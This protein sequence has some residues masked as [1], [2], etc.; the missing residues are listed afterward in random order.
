MRTFFSF[1]GKICCLLVMTA[2]GIS[3][4]AQSYRWENEKYVEPLSSWTGNPLLTVQHDYWDSVRVYPG[5][6]YSRHKFKSLDNY[7]VL[8]INHQT[9][10]KVPDFN[11]RFSFEIRGYRSNG[12]SLY[13]PLIMT[14]EYKKD[15]LQD[16]KDQEIVKLPDS[17]HY[18]EIRLVEVRTNDANNTLVPP[19]SIPAN[20]FLEGRIYCQRY[21]IFTPPVQTNVNVSNQVTNDKLKVYWDFTPGSSWN[22]SQLPNDHQLT[23]GFYEL[24]WMYID[25]Y[26]ITNFDN[27]TSA[28][29]FTSSSFSL[30]YDFRNN[31]TRVQTHRNYYEIPLIYGKGVLIYRV[32]QIRPDATNY[33]DLV[34]GKWT[35]PDAGTLTQNSFGSSFPKCMANV[36][37][38][39]QQAHTQDKVNW[40][41]N[42]SFAEEGRQK[43]V[44]SYFDGTGKSRQVQ[45]RLSSDPGYVVVV[46]Q[47]YDAEGRAAITTLPIPVQSSNLDYKN[48]IAVNALT[49]LP[50]KATDFDNGCAKDT[51]AGLLPGSNGA[52][53]YSEDNPD[54]T[55]MQQF[56]PDA[57]G[58]PF[59]ETIYSPDATNKV[60]WQGGAG[61]DFQRTG[62]GTS[63]T[64]VTAHQKELNRY[65]GSEA[66]YFQYYP[67][68]FVQDPNGES[69][70]SIISP[71][72]KVVLS[73]LAGNA[74][75][76]LEPLNSVPAVELTTFDV[77]R[78]AQQSTGKAY[79]NFSYGFLPEGAGTNTYTY[80]GT[81]IPYATG[82]P[83]KY[84]RIPGYYNI[85]VTTECGETI[86]S[87]S[88]STGATFELTGSAARYRIA[89]GTTNFDPTTD[90]HVI[91]KRLVFPDTTIKAAARAFT[92][93][94]IGPSAC[95]ADSNKFIRAEIERQVFPCTDVPEQS[96]CDLM[97]RSLMDDLYPD[98]KYGIF[99]RNAEGKFGAGDTN[100]IFS[101]VD[102]DGFLF[103][104]PR[105]DKLYKFDISHTDCNVTSVVW[106][107]PPNSSV[108]CP[109]VFWGGG[110]CN[111][112]TFSV[113]LPKE[114]F[115]V[116]D[117]FF[118]KNLRTIPYNNPYRKYVTADTFGHPLPNN[119][120][121]MITGPVDSSDD[122]MKYRYQSSCLG[123]KK[124]YAG[125]L[126]PGRYYQDS[127]L[128]AEL[129]PDQLILVFNDAIA[130][131]LL[132]LHPEYCKLAAC[133]STGFMD[134]LARVQDWND[135]RFLGYETLDDIVAAD[136]LNMA[137]NPSA[138]FN[139]AQLS[140]IQLGYGPGIDIDSFA[141]MQTY[142]SNTFAV[143]ADS[144][145]NR[146]IELEQIADRL[147][148][149]T[150][151]KGL[152]ARNLV[153][154]YTSN[155]TM[156]MQQYRDNTANTCAPCDKLRM[157]IYGSPTIPKIFSG[158]QLD[159]DLDIE[160]WFRDLFNNSLAGIAPNTVPQ[161]ILDALE[162]HNE[163]MCDLQLDEVMEQL[164][165]CSNLTPVNAA[166]IRQYLKDQTPCVASQGE[167][168]TPQAV[169]D[170]ITSVLGAGALDALCNPFLLTYN[171]YNQK[172][173][174]VSA[175]YLPNT[176]AFYEGARAFVN[177]V[178]DSAMRA[179]TQVSLHPLSSPYDSMLAV[180]LQ[181]STSAS[182]NVPF[183][184]WEAAGQQN[185]T[186]GMGSII[187][188]SNGGRTEQIYLAPNYT[189]EYGNSCVPDTTH[190]PVADTIR[191]SA[192]RSILD[193]PLGTQASSV[194][195]QNALLLTGSRA[196]TPGTCHSYVLWHQHMP[197]QRLSTRKE[198]GDVLTCVDIRDGVRA[199]IQ[200][201]L[202][203]G[204]TPYIQTAAGNRALASYLNYRFRK[205]YTA[206]DY[207]DLV[208]GCH[209]SDSL[210]LPEV[211]ADYEITFANAADFTSF[212][213]AFMSA[214]MDTVAFGG[215]VYSSGSGG[216]GTVTLQ[217]NL[218][219]FDFAIWKNIQ[220]YIYNAPSTQQVR[221]LPML[222]SG[223][224]ARAWIRETTAC[225]PALP[226]MPATFYILG[227][228]TTWA[229]VQRYD[230]PASG[231][232]P[233]A[234]GDDL[235]TLLGQ[236]DAMTC[237]RVLVTNSRAYLRTRGS[238][239]ARQAAYVQ[240]IY[241]LGAANPSP[242]VV[243][244]LADVGVLP[245]QH[246]I[247][248]ALANSLYDPMSYID[249]FDA[250][251]VRDLSFPLT[252]NTTATGF[253]A[254][255][256]SRAIGAGP[257]SALFFQAGAQPVSYTGL[258]YNGV[259]INTFMAYQ[260][261]DEGTWYQLFDVQHRR[262]NIFIKSPVSN[263]A[264]MYAYRY[265]P[266]SIKAKPAD[267]DIHG[268][269]LKMRARSTANPAVWDTVTCYGYADFPL[270]T[271]GSL[272]G[273]VL[274]SPARP[275]VGINR[276]TCEQ[277]KYAF[278]IAQGTLKHRRYV[279][280]IINAHYA[281]MK[282][283]FP[284]GTTDTLELTTTEK[285][286]HFTAYY[287][288]LAGNLTRTV[289]PAGIAALPSGVMAT[290]DATRDGGGQSPY[291][292]GHTKQSRYK[293]NSLNQVVWQQTPDGDITTYHYDKF[294]RLAFSQNARQRDLGVYSYTLYDNLS[295]IT[296]TG[297][298]PIPAA[299][300]TYV[301]N[302][303]VHSASDNIKTY[304]RGRNRKYVTTTVYD[305]AL[306]NLQQSGLDAQTNLQNRVSSILYTP[307]LTTVQDPTSYFT[308]ASHF[309]YDVTGNVKTLVQDQPQLDYIN[310]RFKRIDYDYDLLSGKVNQ[311]SYNRGK[312]DQYYHKYEYDAD[313]RVTEV[314][315]S[316][317]G[318]Q[319]DRDAAYTYYKH[320][321]LA[322]VK[323]GD[324][325]LQNLQYA[326]TI[327]GWLKAINADVLNEDADMGKDGQ[328][329]PLMP[330]DVFAHAL[331]YHTG[332]YKAIGTE[333]FMR[334]TG[335]SP[336]TGSLYNGNIAR[337]TTAIHGTG[338]LQR[339]YRY[340]QLNRLLTATYADVDNTT[341]AVTTVPNDGFKN[342][343]SYD[344]DGNITSLLRKDGS[345]TT[346]DNLQ[347]HY[348]NTTNNKLSYVTD[349]SSNRIAGDLDI[350]PGQATG[351]YLYDL[352]GNLVKDVAGNL[353]EITWNSMGKVDVIRNLDQGQYI[354][355]Y[356][357]GL[358]QRVRKDVLTDDG[359]NAID[360]L[361]DYYIRDAQGNILATYKRKA[362]VDNTN[363]ISWL[364]QSIINQHPV[365]M[366]GETQGLPSF[367]AVAMKD[368]PVFRDALFSDPDIISIWGP[369]FLSAAYTVPEYVVGSS[370]IKE[371]AFSGVDF[372]EFY[373]LMRSDYAT[374]LLEQT[375][376]NP[377]LSRNILLPLL[378]PSSQALATGA[379]DNE[380][381]Q[382][383]ES[384]RNNA[385]DMAKTWAISRSLP[386]SNYATLDSFAEAMHAY[387]VIHPNDA[388]NFLH[389]EYPLNPGAEELN[390]LLAELMA[391]PAL[392]TNDYYTDGMRVNMN[393]ELY[394]YLKSNTALNEP[395]S[396]AITTVKTNQ[397]P[398]WFDHIPD[399]EKLS[400]AYDIDAS[401]FLGMLLTDGYID[402]INNAVTAAFTVTGPSGDPVIDWTGYMKTIE[403]ILRI[404]NGPLS[405][406][407]TPPT[408]TLT[409]PDYVLQE[410]LSLGEHH[411][412]GSSRLG[413]KSYPETALKN[414]YDATV[415]PAVMSDM[416][417][418]QRPWYH[419]GHDGL[420]KGDKLVPY[421][422]TTSN[423][424]TR[425]YYLVQ[426]NL[427][428]KHYEITDHLGNVNV[429]ILDKKTG[430]GDGDPG[431]YAYL[432]ANLSSFTDYYP[433][434]MPM[435]GRNGSS[436][437]YRM[438]FNGME[439]DDEIKGK[440]NSLDFGAR[441]YDSRLGRFLSI[442]PEF[443]LQPGQSVYK[444]F[445]NNPLIFTDPSGSTEFFYNGKWIGTD[446][447]NNNLLAKVTDVKLKK[448]ILSFSNQGQYVQFMTR[449]NAAADVPAYTDGTPMGY[450]TV[451]RDVLSYLYKVLDETL[452]SKEIKVGEYSTYMNRNENGNF[453]PGPLEYR[454]GRRS[455]KI[456]SSDISIH[457]HL[458]GVFDVVDQNG[459]PAIEIFS[460][461]DPSEQDVNE[462][463]PNNRINVI[464]GLN[465]Q[466]VDPQTKKD[467]RSQDGS[468]NFYDQILEPKRHNT[469]RMGT[470]GGNEAKNMLKGRSGSTWKKFE[471]VRTN[472]N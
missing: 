5:A 112:T 106:G 442:D 455:Q 470:I 388:Y 280:S 195:S 352:S 71:S 131:H 113:W 439:K 209:L 19:A 249:L 335:G 305:Q 192:A 218:K 422:S 246:T 26:N 308:H 301:T 450:L 61:A 104:T 221:R 256:L 45:T 303:Q 92:Y 238:H 99:T 463:F 286:Y 384:V 314:R 459:N 272:A 423:M 138:P 154:A 375:L 257:D 265:V 152:Y 290:V 233:L 329:N 319:W 408:V 46:D 371:H 60:L 141:V 379:T 68:Q 464:Y 3:A 215:F 73:G 389:D 322:E 353:D 383:L 234:Y 217:L 48:D 114:E 431:E 191:F 367:L 136:P 39:I 449:T 18:F 336:L 151:Y 359:N 175:D 344:A 250:G 332:D 43:S 50:Y 342:S 263:L 74:T 243:I 164:R 35:L 121:G 186:N 86:A 468:I 340:D 385:H 410:S 160:P 170:A 337:Q 55:G 116:C 267:G 78:G 227:A 162:Q 310:Q 351:N 62:K 212:R 382:V 465:G 146:Y 4:T 202:T 460:A 66:G 111:F 284:A 38:F 182:H 287:Y 129:D 259:N 252:S 198:L 368:H 41:H 204:Y 231:S 428:R 105:Q 165:N 16:Y 240:H 266:G 179:A 124:V 316:N 426:R 273:V 453:I 429:T 34:Y 88:G 331:D 435:P 193:H 324:M 87:S 416:L 216:S 166:A 432:S 77:L 378:T 110:G 229:P 341:F 374:Q 183:T 181:L 421:I 364:N 159:P 471:K 57:G 370:Y 49:G 59:I 64:Y 472:I 315:T 446:G 278:A 83:D 176:T 282:L 6:W 85:A 317:D 345:G 144:G 302:A 409:A 103:H 298:V 326:Y 296:E 393:D 178:M 163:D 200:D 127:A 395:V 350:A 239:A 189:Q 412:Y 206:A 356:Y 467:N 194:F 419:L 469:E 94:N 223:T 63:Y 98:A 411:L 424:F 187:T 369:G 28:P 205:S 394:A 180:T 203:Y 37:Y 47:V 219:Q 299:G 224:A 430:T 220:T 285:K 362:K 264:P 366:R 248:G 53:Y 90:R 440:G 260:T 2:S 69:S 235:T 30:A 67:K 137:N 123:D 190:L 361:S 230:V 197:V 414:T 93:A 232:T 58:Y 372:K 438:G 44:V 147:P 253:L 312:A 33:T 117:M 274:G 417:N 347:Y 177:R 392:F 262:Y 109:E 434:G 79:R 167:G 91:D 444:A 398:A 415:Q 236:L 237:A 254:G 148:E 13:M 188:L 17:F 377:D 427:G 241:N 213:T 441:M 289:P 418:V 14:L 318:V 226:Y 84:I 397:D 242:D 134:T 386:L 80:K 360:L 276:F 95:Y 404:S 150:F 281:G 126:W 346:F 158:S 24:E 447:V 456:P 107:N 12:V 122:M 139:A 330:K 294:G 199:F 306:L 457:S 72:G 399:D 169:K 208:K 380:L 407:Y 245:S 125:E 168:I 20:I 102:E 365:W 466:N 211:I 157:K 402:K 295:R 321:P 293:Y 156:R 462:L 297:Q 97:K 309:S 363:F 133:D 96:E 338:N 300:M 228:G 22:C 406:T 436:T 327:Q 244:S 130:E 448:E 437:H 323:L 357:D 270:G 128:V 21:D 56:V 325:N 172:D 420:V 135:A 334:T 452:A 214:F 461:D 403:L 120:S 54:K 405:E 119:R 413:I 451:N 171:K 396:Y 42:L 288:D 9:L 140:T 247:S 27:K 355:F 132:P 275:Q 433:F 32:R 65:F 390:T 358:G 279:D 222:P 108:L 387:L 269:T 291:R 207:L 292:A 313:N 348:Q 283:H 52:L 7:V 255:V 82:C 258:A 320:G 401:V 425:T 8:G 174:K 75:D 11:L 277:D 15:S 339:N 328:S 184:W 185:A 271:G 443:K 145:Y 210:Y 354:S 25:N 196:A 261:S 142:I 10:L 201:T 29:R 36:M 101:L 268:F 70:F 251:N 81:I 458:T 445:L 381:L 76:N 31:A 153:S 304:V 23:P 100:S 1:L 161:E 115:P 118:Q 149:Q 155:R 376:E 225:A 307:S 349:L 89:P 400:T 51:I 343:Y 373:D 173:K 40:M 333:D 391:S 454:E 311:L 143:V